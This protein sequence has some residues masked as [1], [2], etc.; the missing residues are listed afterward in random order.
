MSLPIAE[1]RAERRLTEIHQKQISSLWDRVEELR[2]DYSRAEGR[3]DRHFGKLQ[4]L[5]HLI[6]DNA[7]PG[8]AEMRECRAFLDVDAYVREVEE[9]LP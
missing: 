3:A 2:W 1:P 4:F 6:R 9:T 7:L 5:V 8:A